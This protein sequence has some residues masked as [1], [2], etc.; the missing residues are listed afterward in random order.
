MQFKLSPQMVPS[1]THNVS[2]I[3]LFAK[4]TGSSSTQDL[5]DFAP[6][7]L[8]AD[9]GRAGDTPVAFGVKSDPGGRGSGVCCSVK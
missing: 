5:A 9:H 7:D 1:S 6:S 8:A 4:L 2:E 3:E